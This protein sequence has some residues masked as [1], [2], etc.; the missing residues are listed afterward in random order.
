MTLRARLYSG[1]LLVVMILALPVVVFAATGQSSSTNYSV[2]QVHFGSGGQLKA[3]ST[4]YCAKQSTGDLS[5]GNT[6]SSNYNAIAGGNTDRNEYLQFIVGATTINTGA[7]STSTTS[8]ATATFSVKSYLSSGYTVINASAPPKSGTNVMHALSSPAAAVSGT[9]QFG[10]NLVANTSPVTFGASPVQTPDSTFGFGQVGAG[11]NTP[12]NYK[13]NNGDT[14][15]YSTQ[16]SG[17]TDYTISYIFNIS[18]VTPGGTY[19][20]NHVLIATAT[21]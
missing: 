7:L 8:T 15:A 12:N 20:M 3:C 6:K 14:I 13:Y 21:F 16:S 2:D 19:T 4:N 5:V 10:I 1:F 9:E 11:Y 17:E 18:S